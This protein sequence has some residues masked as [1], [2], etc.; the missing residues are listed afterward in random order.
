MGAETRTTS[1][2]GASKGVKKQAFDR[3]PPRALNELAKLYGRGAAKYAPNNFRLGYE[4]PKSFAAGQRHGVLFWA[5][6]DYDTETGCH[7]ISSTVWHFFTI[8]ESNQT[9]PAFDRRPYDAPTRALNAAPLHTSKVLSRAQPPKNI[10]TPYRH[11]LI[12]LHPYARV[13]EVFG[14]APEILELLGISEDAPFIKIPDNVTYG[15]LYGLMQSYAHLYWSG[16][17]LDEATGLPNLAFAAAYGMLLLELSLS[18]PEADDRFLLGAPL[19][20]DSVPAA[21]TIPAPK[22][23]PSALFV[24]SANADSQVSLS[25]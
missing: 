21:V 18:R 20:F 23:A 22:D 14:A 25:V 2:T 10:P 4:T 6:E 19:G 17:D 8:M 5:G 9:H 7:H 11:D 1:S 12:P 15:T 13:A 3:I 16:E 24:A